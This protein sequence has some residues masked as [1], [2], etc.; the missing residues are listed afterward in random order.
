MKAENPKKMNNIYWSKD[1]I[2]IITHGHI[3]NERAVKNKNKLPEI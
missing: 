1:L 2:M 3:N